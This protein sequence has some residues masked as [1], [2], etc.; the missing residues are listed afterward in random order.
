MYPAKLI[1]EVVIRSFAWRQE[2]LQWL[3]LPGGTHQ[4]IKMPTGRGD[5]DLAQPR[6][7]FSIRLTV[8]RRRVRE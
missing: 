7:N 5:F 6:Q 8:E 3:L 1:L 4:K 2:R